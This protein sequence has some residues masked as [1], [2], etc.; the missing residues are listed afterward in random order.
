LEWNKIVNKAV[1]LKSKSFKAIIYFFIVMIILTI[2]ARIADTMLLPRVEAVKMKKMQLEYPVEISGSISG[3]E[4][5]SIG[6]EGGITV[7]RVLVAVDDIVEKGDVLYTL[8]LD[9]I[10]E[11]VENIEVELLKNQMQIAVIESENQNQKK[12][13]DKNVIRAKED[14][15]TV[16]KTSGE[17]VNQAYEDLMNAKKELTELERNLT[18]VKV[19]IKDEQT[20]A[21]ASEETDET[22]ETSTSSQDLEQ[23]RTELENN[24]K[25]LNQAYEEAIATRNSELKAA[26]RQLEDADIP[27]K[28]DNS[29][30]LLEI[31]KAKLDE[32]LNVLKALEQQQGKIKSKYN[33]KISEINVTPGSQTLE[34]ATVQ[35]EDFNKGFQFKGVITEEQKAYLESGSEGIVY[36]ESNMIEDVKI[37][38][39]SIIDGGNYQVIAKLPSDIIEQP[40]NASFEIIKKSKK[41]DNC[42][43]IEA[44]YKDEKGSFIYGLEESETLLGKQYIVVP[45]SVE[46]EEENEKYAAF[47]SSGRCE[48]YITNS[49]KQIDEGDRVYFIEKL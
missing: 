16:E 20:N 12:E 49:D 46:I 3:A 22:E 14:Y 6:C 15:A 33:G 44:V 1:S 5:Q 47:N 17:V 31:D 29:V 32:S 13:H 39:I 37:N 43:P 35:I 18:I 40:G 7:K 34:G 30:L 48:Y 21:A 45:I 8:D 19:E 38:R 42:L 11:L 2:I 28:E 27:I 36:T 9:H 26:R 10:Q 41:Y 23:I 25:S 4:M 24:L